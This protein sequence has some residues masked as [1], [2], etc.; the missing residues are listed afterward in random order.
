LA[1]WRSS[2]A[3]PS[4]KWQSKGVIIIIF[5]SI[6]MNVLPLDARCYRTL[7]GSHKILRRHKKCANLCRFAP[8]CTAGLILSG[9]IQSFCRAM[10]EVFDF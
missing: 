1:T 8:I 4:A 6:V 5:V 2:G 3:K 10:F 7:G 9:P